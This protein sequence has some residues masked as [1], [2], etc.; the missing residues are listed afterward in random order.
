MSRIDEAFPNLK[1]IHTRDELDQSVGQEIK[2]HELLDLKK[3]HWSYSSD[4]KGHDADGFIKDA[5]RGMTVNFEPFNEKLFSDTF[6]NRSTALRRDYAQYLQG[7]C[8]LMNF[9]S[10][11]EGLIVTGS[12]HRPDFY[13]KQQQDFFQ[14]FHIGVKVIKFPDFRPK[15]NIPGIS[16]TLWVHSNTDSCG[17]VFEQFQNSNRLLDEL[18]LGNHDVEITPEKIEAAYQEELANIAALQERLEDL[19][20]QSVTPKA[21]DSESKDSDQD[22]TSEIKITSILLNDTVQSVFLYLI[23][24]TIINHLDSI[25]GNKNDDF[26]SEFRQTISTHKKLILQYPEEFCHVLLGLARRGAFNSSNFYNFS[27]DLMHLLPRFYSILTE[28]NLEPVIQIFEKNAF[29]ISEN[30]LLLKLR[31]ESWVCKRK[32]DTTSLNNALINDI[33]RGHVSIN[34]KLFSHHGED[35]KSS[36]E[37]SQIIFEQFEQDQFTSKKIELL[38]SHYDQSL[39]S[40][41]RSIASLSLQDEKF[42]AAATPLSYFCNFYQQDD[43]ICARTEFWGVIIKP[44]TGGTPQYFIPG[45][46]KSTWKDFTLDQSGASNSILAK[47]CYGNRNV[48]I[49]AQDVSYAVQQ[50]IRNIW[51]MEQELASS[52]TK[53]TS[54]DAKDEKDSKTDKIKIQE[55]KRHILKNTLESVF[56]C[57]IHTVLNEESDV[58]DEKLA[59]I[60]QQFHTMIKKYHVE[61]FEVLSKYYLNCQQTPYLNGL[62]TLDRFLRINRLNT[63]TAINQSIEDRYYSNISHCVEQD[64]Q[65][66]AI[67]HL[68]YVYRNLFPY[69]S[70]QSDFNQL[71]QTANDT[72]ISASTKQELFEHASEHV[73]R[74]VKHHKIS[75]KVQFW[76]YFKRLWRATPNNSWSKRLI[77][78]LLIKALF[79]VT[80]YDLLGEE[81][82]TQTFPKKDNKY[83]NTA[84]DYKTDM[85]S[86]QDKRIKPRA[87]F[88]EK[89]TPKKYSDRIQYLSFA[90]LRNSHMA[91][92]PLKL[93]SPKSKG[94]QANRITQESHSHQQSIG[95]LI[96]KYLHD[97]DDADKENCLQ[98]G[99]S[100]PYAR[101]Y[102]ALSSLIQDL[103]IKQLN[104]L[105]ALLVESKW[106]ENNFRHRYTLCWMV[107]LRF[108]EKQIKF[109]KAII[110][111]DNF[112]DSYHSIYRDIKLMLQ[113]TILNEKHQSILL[114]Q[115]ERANNKRQIIIHAKQILLAYLNCSKEQDTQSKFLN[116]NPSF[117][118]M[119]DLFSTH[120]KELEISKLVM[121]NRLID[122]F[123]YS[124]QEK[125]DL[126]WIISLHYIEKQIQALYTK[127][128]QEFNQAYNQAIAETKDYLGGTILNRTT[129]NNLLSR[130]KDV[131]DERRTIFYLQA[132]L[133]EPHQ[134]NKQ[135]CLALNVSFSTI[136][137]VI[138]MIA[139]NLVAEKLQLLK[140]LIHEFNYEPFQKDILVDLAKQKISVSKIKTAKKAKK[141]KEDH[142]EMQFS[143]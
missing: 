7:G 108:I 92:E 104:S 123:S 22:I 112:Q 26:D 36:E 133:N 45:F 135:A 8:S 23:H 30:E 38:K 99:N 63:N 12:L 19:R 111:N 121:L 98:F 141:D 62:I 97:L 55:E 28:S 85:D 51:R 83:T 49:T 29:K 102:Q 5:T 72:I 53:S 20:H 78:P 134:Q 96:R 52:A 37:K 140:P 4:Y 87:A 142:T 18:C 68:L 129:Q 34:G 33:W 25:D 94:I 114:S 11:Q 46:F 118:L 74:Y 64:K 10:L 125:H 122:Q 86:E 58:S 138:E 9:Q 84:T 15:F 61:F 54:I 80:R 126:A 69:F 21:K 128:D 67:E 90:A 32:G 17:Y 131:Q 56:C 79:G 31:K 48:D 27:R 76:P 81:E 91:G 70:R 42:T 50:E 95:E 115:I 137:K 39:L 75:I 105:N 59:E 57:L 132:Y 77:I 1:Y 88:A 24:P 6:K 73:D 3:N 107:N 44:R 109:L 47:L 101:M 136:K 43:K 82:Q 127:S 13:T 116:L 65:T 106:Y 2:N 89:S 103:D 113:K 124:T 139:P 35:E 40:L 110:D 143:S 119:R 60:Y 117:S 130:I 120:I 41:P 14:V 66:E 93:P 16:R 100:V 71:I